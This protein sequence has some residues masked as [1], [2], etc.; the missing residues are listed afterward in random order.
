MHT[1][2][3]LAEGNHLIDECTASLQD[4]KVNAYNVC[5]FEAR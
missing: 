3:T 4:V 2:E 5:V 1:Q